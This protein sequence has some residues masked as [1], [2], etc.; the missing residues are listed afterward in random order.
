MLVLIGSNEME[1]PMQAFT[2]N[3]TYTDDTKLIRWESH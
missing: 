1:I 3:T 2:V